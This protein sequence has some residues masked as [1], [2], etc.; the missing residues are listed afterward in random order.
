MIDKKS[1]IILTGLPSI[2]LLVVY[3]PY[4]RPLPA[5]LVIFNETSCLSMFY[6]I[7]QSFKLNYSP[8]TTMVVGLSLHGKYMLYNKKSGIIR[9]RFF[10]NLI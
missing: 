5:Y 10:I 4:E 3:I 1:P 9:L 6:M 7:R 2:Q 8:M